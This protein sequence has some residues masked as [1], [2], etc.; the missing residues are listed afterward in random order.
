MSISK[1]GI[2]RM[3]L[4]TSGQMSQTAPTGLLV[5]G[6]RKPGLLTIAPFDT[7]K[8]HRE[9]DLRNLM[10][11]KAEISS[12]QGR[13][14]FLDQLITFV[15]SGYDLQVAMNPQGGDADSGG[16][17]N[18][19]AQVAGLDFDMTLGAK[20]RFINYMFETAMEYEAFQT[21]IA[22]SDDEGELLPSIAADGISG[23]N[24][25]GLN[26]GLYAHPYYASI[27]TPNASEIFSKKE[28][29][30]RKFS[31]KTK[32]YKNA[33][34]ET[35]E[36]YLAVLLEMT[37][38]DATIAKMVSLL[39]VTM[40]PTL[41]VKE[42]IGGTTYYEKY[43]FAANLLTHREEFNLGDEKR[44]A[45]IIFEGN[46]LPS[47]FSFAYGSANG[48]AGTPTTETEKLAGGTCTI[49]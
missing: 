4:T 7:L 42:Y 10:N 11:I 15:G 2:K 49:S 14:R 27:E 37:G 5:T 33:Y 28:I 8:D 44:E 36:P 45:K 34:N 40:S 22:A 46:L 35:V 23:G 1:R 6:S 20:E 41:T 3:I 16:V 48:G 29:V 25:E 30:D 9:R 32:G 47:N 39:A 38:A 26:F 24:E 18:F 19:L 43:V 13:M 17:L 12:Y 21:F 31:I